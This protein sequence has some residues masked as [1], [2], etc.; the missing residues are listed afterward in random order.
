[1]NEYSRLLHKAG[2]I[3]GIEGI[4]L[5]LGLGP[6]YLENEKQKIHETSRIITVYS[7][8]Q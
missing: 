7:V 8:L 2:G 5:S 6:L 1:M 4:G 3:N